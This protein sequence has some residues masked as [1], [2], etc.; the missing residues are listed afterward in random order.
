MSG[1]C[2]QESQGVEVLRMLADRWQDAADET[3]SP[4]LRACYTRRAARY[5]ELAAS[6]VSADPAIQPQ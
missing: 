5:R 6:R 4:V 1:A 3:Q 2:V